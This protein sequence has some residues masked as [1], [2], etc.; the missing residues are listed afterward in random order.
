MEGRDEKRE[1]KD[2]VGRAKRRGGREK[3]KRR[4]EYE[5]EHEIWGREREITSGKGE[6]KWGGGRDDENRDE[7][8]RK[9]D[10]WWKRG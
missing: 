7:L 10:R 4:G 6:M 1:W 3:R 9:K 2:D 5:V 8:W